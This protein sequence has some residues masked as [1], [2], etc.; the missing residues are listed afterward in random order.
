MF[1][2][3]QEVQEAEFRAVYAQVSIF[4]HAFK[5]GEIKFNYRL[6]H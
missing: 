4:Y 1:R 6:D 3:L 5:A 2:R